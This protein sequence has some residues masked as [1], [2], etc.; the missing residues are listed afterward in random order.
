M[1]ENQIAIIHFQP[2]EKFPPAINLLNYFLKN[3]H[4]DIVVISTALEKT[5]VLKAYN[6]KERKLAVIRTPAILAGSV[7]RIVNYL[8]FFMCSLFTIIKLRPPVILYFESIS[9][10]PALMYKKIMGKRVRLFA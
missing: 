6:P 9:S 10:W 2:L 8:Y 7:Y 5:T 1:P 3:A 4:G